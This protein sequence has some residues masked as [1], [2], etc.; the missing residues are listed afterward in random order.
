MSPLSNSPAYWRCAFVAMLIPSL[1]V[2]PTQVRGQAAGTV[3]GKVTAENGMALS[4]ASVEVEG[5]KFRT[6]TDDQGVFRVTGMPP[7]QANIQVK[8]L[9]FRP[10]AELRKVR[11]PAFDRPVQVHDVE[12]RGAELL[13]LQGHRDRILGIDRLPAHVSLPET[14][15]APVLQ[16]Y[17]GNQKHGRPFCSAPDING[18]TARR[19]E[20]CGSRARRHTRP[21]PRP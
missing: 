10:V 18:A 4:G 2:T 13:P 9:G 1:A 15:T 6:L 16:V 7:G 5:T 21:T 3:L 8:R 14:D 19:T 12:Q 17:G 20:N 11:R